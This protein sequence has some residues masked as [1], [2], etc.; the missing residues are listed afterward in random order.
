[1][2]EIVDFAPGSADPHGLTMRYGKLN[3]CDAGIHPGWPN[4]DSPSNGYIFE[5]NLA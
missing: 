4:F 3:S 2:L 1:L 5:I